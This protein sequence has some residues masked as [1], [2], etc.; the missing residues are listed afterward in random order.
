MRRAPGGRWYRAL[1]RLGLA[2]LAVATPPRR[3]SAQELTPPSVVELA[4]LALVPESE[5]TVTVTIDGAGL[6]V[7]DSCEAAAE[8]CEAARSALAHSRFEP[9]R[10]DGAPITSRTRVK[11]RRPALTTPSTDPPATPPGATSEPEP[12]AR[13]AARP[14]EAPASPLPA[15]S[16]AEDE[17]LAFTARART[18]TPQPAARRLELA[19]TR[20]MPGG[21]G[22]PLRAIESL[23][24][25]VPIA[26]GVPYV[27][28][29]G[30]PPSG[31]LYLY[32]GIPLPQLFHLAL[33]PAVVHPRMLGAM[34]LH[35]GAAP[36]RYG[37][38]VGGVIVAEGP[39]EPIATEPAHGE[40]ELRLLDLN[41]YVDV[42]VLGGRVAAALRIGWTSLLSSL[43]VPGLE[44]GFG[45]YQLRASLPIGAGERFELVAL[46]SYDRLAYVAEDGSPT[47]A[48]VQFQRVEGRIRA[49]SGA[50]SGLAAIRAGWD[51]TSYRDVIGPLSAET[52]HVAVRFEGEHRDPIY[53]LRAGGDAMASFGRNP[54]AQLRNTWEP[55]VLGAINRSTAALWAELTVRPVPELALVLGARSD[56]WL[57]ASRLEGALDPRV[58]IA[59]T[60]VTE[61][62][63]HVG[64]GITRQPP[65]YYLPVPGTNDLVLASGLQTAMQLDLGARV[66]HGW[67]RAEL[68]LFVH[69]YEDLVFS[70]FYVLLNVTPICDPLVE[71]PALCVTPGLVP[72]T[73]GVSWGGEALI[74]IAPTE[75][76]SG[77]VSY[78]LSWSEVDPIYGIDLRPSYDVRHVANVLVRWEPVSGL[79]FGA[80]VHLRSGAPRGIFYRDFG[81]PAQ[82]SLQRL[83]VEMTPFGR[84]DLQVAYAWDAGWGRLRVSVDWLNVTFAREA[85]G[86]L[87]HID[88]QGLPSRCHTNRAPAIVAPNIG[89]RMEI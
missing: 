50:F 89:L 69:R 15:E 59:W 71:S 29:R 23:P 62:T 27:F 12:A 88:R 85:V 58:R 28:L 9:A 80:R 84:L 33:G 51:R 34:E 60:P 41:G 2:A 42:P 79:T 13:P 56:A 87:C 1:V 19:E 38:H 25:V 32:D 39:G 8:I 16:A 24:G 36:A 75:P 61:L 48:E 31:T 86:L 81:R 52:G 37:R 26:N 44:I 55:D 30:S 43:F 66:E 63:L 65:S 35:A 78:T 10:R 72:R 46:G 82:E 7:L 20:D 22:D 68:Q 6:A 64:G 70:D 5:L 4:P 77:W 45:D 11:W 57:Y 53:T 17:D 40:L 14:S 83:D 76:L 73:N 18:P 54:D 3:A 21:L 49:R 67:L 47:D 74:A